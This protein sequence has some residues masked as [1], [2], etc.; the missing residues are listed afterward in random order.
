M[1]PTPCRIRPS[2]R[3]A[4]TA[5]SFCRS[6]PAAVFRGLTNGGLPACACRS[7]S[8]LNA[9]TGRNTSPLTSSVAGHPAPRRRAGAAAIVL[10]F[11]VTSSPV[12]PSPL[13]AARAGAVAVDQVDRQAVDLELAQE[14]AAP[15]EPLRPGEPVA[16][17][18]C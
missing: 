12:T 2:G 7:F 5:G 16:E 18:V 10:T 6:D 14:R 13:V 1:A 17:L 4:V 11:A 3:L 15:A 8:S 9:T